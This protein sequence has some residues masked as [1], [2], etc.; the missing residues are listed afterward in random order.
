[1]TNLIASGGKLW[2][3]WIVA[4]VSFGLLATPTWADEPRSKIA[5]LSSLATEENHIRQRAF[6]GKTDTFFESTE[7]VKADDHFT[8]IFDE[9]A[10]VQGV[11]VATG[12]PDGAAK[13]SGASVEVSADGT[14]FERVATI[15][16][17]GTGRAD[18][19]ERKL[20][21][22]R[23]KA[24]EALPD[25]LVIREFTIDSP[26]VQPFQHPV[27]FQ[28]VCDDAPDL[29][30]WTEE[31]ARLCE[32]WYDALTEQMATENYEPTDHVTMILTRDYKGVAA[33]GGGRI[34]G[35]VA[36]FEKHK[37][38]Q[39]AMIHETIHIIQ[40]Y[41]GRRNPGWLVEGVADYFRCFFYE[42]GKVRPVNPDTAKYNQSYQVTATFLDYVA[43]TH[44][45]DLVKKL[46]KAMRAGTYDKA[47][48]EQITGKSIEALNDDWIASI[49]A[50]KAKS[51]PQ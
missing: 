49:R 45:K 8:L 30:T 9:P 25:P 31:T 14:T 33:A 46:N 20:K 3:A 47:L 44:D 4:G 12:R 18:L 16:P 40:H 13:L 32:Q 28:V 50:S 41:R 15:G 36:Y 10:T 19:P 24:T 7:P 37:K 2:G 29:K 51:H 26:Q 42:P 39:G 21:A 17:D 22:V 38:D 1:M 11:G 43:R 6:D 27:E 34:T 48:F 5:V 23:V 35:S